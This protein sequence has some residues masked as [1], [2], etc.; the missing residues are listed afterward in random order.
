MLADAFIN[1]TELPTSLMV[2]KYLFVTIFP[3]KCIHYI[4]CLQQSYLKTIGEGWF[5]AVA[6][7]SITASSLGCYTTTFSRLSSEL[8]KIIVNMQDMR[9]RER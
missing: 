4:K 1:K 2:S 5:G 9:V 3:F 7:K 8:L 6:Q